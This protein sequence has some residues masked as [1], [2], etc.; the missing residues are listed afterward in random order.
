MLSSIVKNFPAVVY[1]YTAFVDDDEQRYFF[2]LK[3]LS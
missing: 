3:T 1:G 2:T